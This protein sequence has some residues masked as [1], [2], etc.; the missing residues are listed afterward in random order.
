MA[1]PTQPADTVVCPNGQPDPPYRCRF[2]QVW[3]HRGDSDCGCS[4]LRQTV[5]YYA[6]LCHACAEALDVL[7]A[8]TLVGRI[9]RE[10]VHQANMAGRP[11]S[12]DY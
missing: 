6:S 1:D 5:T 4:E 12:D 11:S 8:D 2:C 9:H 3:V 10:L 7:T